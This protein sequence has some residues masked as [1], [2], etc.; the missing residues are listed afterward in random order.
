M[1]EL[2]LDVDEA[3]VHGDQHACVAVS[4]VVEGGR[5]RGEFGVLRGA[6]EGGAH[7][8]ALQASAG[9]TGEHNRLRCC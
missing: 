7:D 9:A 5:R 6:R 1:A 8:F 3:A 4:E 2:V